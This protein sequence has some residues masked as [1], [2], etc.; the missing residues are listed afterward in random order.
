MNSNISNKT[1]KG[2]QNNTSGLGIFVITCKQTKHRL[3]ELKKTISSLDNY[4]EIHIVEKLDADCITN[5]IY[6]KDNWS[7]DFSEIENVLREN[8]E[9]LKI[10][11]KQ[12]SGILTAERSCRDLKESEISLASKIFYGLNRSLISNYAYTLILED[13]FRYDPEYNPQGRRI[14]LTDIYIEAEKNRIDFIDIGSLPALNRLVPEYRWNAGKNLDDLCIKTKLPKT[15][16]TCGFLISRRLLEFIMQLKM[17]HSLPIDYEL[18]RRFCLCD[19]RY[20]SYWLKSKIFCN[21]SM[22]ANNSIR[23]SIQ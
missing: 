7:S 10:Y 3:N 18:Q 17:H 16:S 15:R 2:E 13:D 9:G 23:S 21:A 4:G 8:L 12:I 22:I 20:S 5:K 1:D 6:S 11:E 14:Q 19:T